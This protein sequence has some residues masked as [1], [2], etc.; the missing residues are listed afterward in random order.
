VIDPLDVKPDPTIFLTDVP[1]PE[2]DFILPVSIAN[3]N[4]SAGLL[5]PDAIAIRIFP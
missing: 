2:N 4:P 3:T 5:G 1:K